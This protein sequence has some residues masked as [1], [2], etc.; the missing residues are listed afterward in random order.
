MSL[1]NNQL[2]FQTV[3]ELPI[4]LKGSIERTSN[5]LRKTER[6]QHATNW[7]WRHEDLNQWC[8]EFSP[9][10][11]IQP[12]QASTKYLQKVVKVDLC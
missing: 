1:R 3:G 5:E 7:A 4:M 12:Y 8:L 10:M 2:G 9:D 11:D 6:S